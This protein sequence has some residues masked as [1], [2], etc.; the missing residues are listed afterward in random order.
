MRYRA[1][2]DAQAEIYKKKKKKTAVCLNPRAFKKIESVYQFVSRCFNYMEATDLST[3]KFAVNEARR[4]CRSVVT[5]SKVLLSLHAMP[6]HVKLFLC[7]LAQSL[8]FLNSFY[9][10]VQTC[11]ENFYT[12]VCVFQCQR[13]MFRNDLPRLKYS[14]SNVFPTIGIQEK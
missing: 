6:R 9:K 11:Y 12:R 14:F 3:V 1:E 10:P 7:F 4:H 8:S 5:V 13:F 2:T